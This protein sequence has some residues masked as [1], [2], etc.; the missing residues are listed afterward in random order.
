MTTGY[1]SHK[2]E[3]SGIYQASCRDR[4]QIALSRGDTFPPCGQC[5]QG[6]T[7]YLIQKTVN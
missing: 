1:T 5:R 2:C 3:V 7:W 4:T 6:V